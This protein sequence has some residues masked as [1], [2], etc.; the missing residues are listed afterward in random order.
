MAK[1][2]DGMYVPALNTPMD[3]DG[4][5][6]ADVLFYHGTK[7]TIPSGCAAIEVGAGKG[8]ALTDGDHGTLTWQDDQPQ[9][10]RVWYADGRQYLYPIPAS[11]IL[12]NPELKQNPGWQQ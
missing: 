10:R 6:T 11:A 5:G 7:P 12:L 3:L 4:D 9:L 8:S 1:R 2:W